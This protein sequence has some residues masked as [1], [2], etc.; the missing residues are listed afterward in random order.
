[1]ERR[2]DQIVTELEEHHNDPDSQRPISESTLHA[3]QKVLDYTIDKDDPIEIENLSD[4][5][6]SKNLSLSTSLIPSLTSAMGSGGPQHSLLA[7]KVYLSFLLTPNSN[8]LSLFTPMAFLSLLRTIRCAFKNRSSGPPS[9]N[10][11]KKKRG[12]GGRG[13]NK[14]K[15]VEVGDDEV[16]A[17]QATHEFDVRTIFPVLERLHLVLGLVHL[18]RFPDSLKAIVQ[19]VTEIPV[20]ALDSCGN[21]S[22]YNKLCSFCSEILSELLK[23]EHGDKI[24]TAAEI[25]R[26][27]SSSIIMS[28]SQARIFGLAFVVDKMASMA[29]D[30]DEIRKCLLN[31]PKYLVCKAPERAELRALAVESILEI[32]KALEHKDQTDFVDYVVNMTRG[33]PQLRLLGVD[34]IHS[35]ITSLDDPLGASLENGYE[36]SWGFKCLQALVERCSDATAGIRARAITNLAQLVGFLSGKDENKIG[37]MKVMGFGEEGGINDVLRKRCVDEKA[38][39][40]KAALVLISKLTTFQGEGSGFDSMLLKIMGVA[41]SDQLVSIRKAAISALSETFRKFHDENVTKEWLHSVPRLIADNE[42]SIQEECENL[43]LELVLDRISRAGSNAAFL[44]RDQDEVLSLLKEICHGEVTPWIKKI[45]TNLGKKSKLKPKVAISLQNI[46]RK[47]ESMWLAESKPIEKWLAPAGAWFLLSEVSG[48]LLKAVD[49][50][51]LYHHWQLLD[52]HESI[53]SPPAAEEEEE[54]I[55]VESNSVD[56][57]GNRVA[58]LQTISNVSVELPAEPAADLAH[59]LLKRIEEFNMHS[60]EVS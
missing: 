48:Y 4:E 60:M 44:E 11:G 59:N 3:L 20:M 41:C 27:L 43:F 23:S 32:V 18:D 5:L 54:A 29:K 49:W 24:I 40:R 26:C 15:S 39:V 55:G 57:A 12:G 42:T 22:N 38:A 2:I 36:S 31:F 25:L 58:L 33:K 53:N 30:S 10:A 17:S 28:K 37:L 8:V 6:S 14:G 46:I 50:E 13:K 7:S 56:W 34:L 1:M 35:L 9:G 21:S 51:F 19:T 16:E 52:K 47:S 45:C